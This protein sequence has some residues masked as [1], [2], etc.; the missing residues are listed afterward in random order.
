MLIREREESK[1]EGCGPNEEKND[2]SSTKIEIKDQE[3]FVGRKMG[4][5]FLKLYFLMFFYFG[6]LWHMEF[7]GQS[8][9][10]L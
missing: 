5:P 1:I 10:P 7:P 2:I 9:I 8:Q 3:R 4:L 6:C